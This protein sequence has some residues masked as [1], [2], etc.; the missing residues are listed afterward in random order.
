[1]ERIN[2]EMEE[3]REDNMNKGLIVYT[4]ARTRRKCLRPATTYWYL[5]DTHGCAHTHTHIHSRTEKHTT[6]SP[7]A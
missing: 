1:M 2:I 5:R 7:I 4:N 6:N 3:E